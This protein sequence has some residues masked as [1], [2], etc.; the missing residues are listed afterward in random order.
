VTIDPS[1]ARKQAPEP[2]DGTGI[3]ACLAK[4]VPERRYGLYVAYPANRADVSMAADG[5]RDFA[6]EAA[7][8]DA[9]WTYMLKSPNVGLWHAQG[10][11]G[12][13]RIV[14][15]Y[16]YRGPDWQ[17][18]AADGS[19]QVIKAGDWLVGIVWEP[20]AWEAVK[21]GRINGVSMQGTATR[22]MP[23]PEALAALRQ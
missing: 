5:Y 2:W 1:A 7:V 16:V 18:T 3:A 11:D 22:R 6:G 12:A 10:T 9:A 13:G 19:A 4:A 17:L 15:S 23:S 14:E 20:D 8:E 21:S